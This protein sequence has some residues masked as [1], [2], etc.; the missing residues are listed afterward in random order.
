[1]GQCMRNTSLDKGHKIVTLRRIS[2]PSFGRSFSF[3]FFRFA[4]FSPSFEE[5]RL[6]VISS[7]FLPRQFSLCGCENLW[8]CFRS[9]FFNLKLIVYFFFGKGAIFRKEYEVLW[10]VSSNVNSSLGEAFLNE[11]ALTITSVYC[12]IVIRFVYKSYDTFM[13]KMK[14]IYIYE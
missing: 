10:W 8:V 13:W 2:S 9:F 7:S 1:L 4:L 14:H 3:C 5:G 6:S 11:S 12:D